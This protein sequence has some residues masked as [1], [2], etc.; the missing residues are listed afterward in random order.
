MANTNRSFISSENSTTTPLVSPTSPS[1]SSLN[2]A[3]HF[4]SIKLTTTNYLLWKTQLVPFLHDQKLLD[5]IDGTT[6]CPSPT[7]TVF[8]YDEPQP[9]PTASHWKGQDQLLL[10][11]LISSLN[12]TVFSLV[13]GLNTYHEVWSTLESTFASLSN[14][15]ILNLHMQL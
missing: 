8:G 4:L 3:H 6:R 15:R 12:E 1:T 5:H 13:V 14:T 2:H 7:I 9:N 10:S 11:L